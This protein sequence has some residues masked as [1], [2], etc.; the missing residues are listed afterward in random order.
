LP[1][2]QTIM[3]PSIDAETSIIQVIKDMFTAR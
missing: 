2:P 3:V 1:S